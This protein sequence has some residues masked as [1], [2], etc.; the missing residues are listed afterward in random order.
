[1]KKLF[2][3]QCQKKRKRILQKKARKLQ[4]IETTQ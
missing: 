2:E 3:R 4:D 1:M